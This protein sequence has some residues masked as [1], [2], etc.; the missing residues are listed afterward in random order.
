MSTALVKLFFVSSFICSNA[1]RVHLRNL[2][3]H[4]T[5][6]TYL[7]F[8]SRDETSVKD[9]AESKTWDEVVIL[10]NQYKAKQKI[11][12]SIVSSMI[13]TSR[14]YGKY[15]ECMTQF[16]MM[17][18]N[19][20]YV[21][22]YTYDNVISCNFEQGYH[23][24]AVD[25]TLD[26]L[27][28]NS[29]STESDQYN[30]EKTSALQGSKRVHFE[31]AV[32]TALRACTLIRKSGH[33]DGLHSAIAIFSLLRFRN[34]VLS[35][36]M[37]AAYITCLAVNRCPTS[38][39]GLADAVHH[40]FSEPLPDVANLEKFM[41]FLHEEYP[42]AVLE[43]ISPYFIPNPHQSGAN[44]QLSSKCFTFAMK[45][46]VKALLS[47][48][49]AS[50]TVSASRSV[51][52]YNLKNSVTAT[53]TD[54]AAETQSAGKYVPALM[55]EK[56]LIV[57]LVQRERDL[58][59][60]DMPLLLQALSSCRE[61]EDAQA[62][63]QVYGIAKQLSREGKLSRAHEPMMVNPGEVSQQKDKASSADFTASAMISGRATATSG[64][65]ITEN[66][67][68][69]GDGANGIDNIRQLAVTP[70]PSLP[71]IVYGQ[72]AVALAKGGAEAQ[73]F[74]V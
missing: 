37:K 10:Y 20:P 19:F 43:A 70:V 60:L 1:L 57:A 11:P 62:A 53:A 39:Q 41:S 32:F 12:Y 54:A 14:K 51:L 31:K 7:K 15:D 47:I 3:L 21:N 49:Y 18:K 69:Q 38:L 66:F 29:T 27:R 9:F 64:T 56:G 40:V 59:L 42:L 50:P 44:L 52:L 34:H 63:W 35:R 74:Q 22:Y 67:R 33:D 58:G 26:M 2:R 61:V 46:A 72:T 55:G 23:R 48:Q 6:S 5:D 25:I 8:S 36:S 68:S 4:G 71:S 73:T 45:C 30:I 24:R 13:A 17:T 16:N 28:S 65:K